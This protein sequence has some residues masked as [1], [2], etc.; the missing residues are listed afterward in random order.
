MPF[1][2]AL[3]TAAE[4][5]RAIEETC[6]RA[7]TLGEGQP[8]LVLTFFSLDH[9]PHA[10]Q[11]AA[12]LSQQF[13]PRC[14][15]GCMGESIVGNDQEIEQQPALSLWLGRWNQPVKVEPFHLTLEQTPDGYSL[16]GWP[17]GI[18][19]ADPA[20]SALL[21]LGDPFTFPTD[22]FLD[23]VN[24]NHVG[25]RVMGGM[26]SGA[27]E[28]GQSRLILG[29]RVLSE[30][31]VGVLLQGP[32]KIRSIVSQGCRP[33]GRHL[34][35]TKA[36]ENIIAGLGGKPPLAH[37]QQLWPELNKKDQQLLQHGLHVGRVIN[38]YQGEFQRG[39]FLVR[40]VL[41]LDQE[42]GAMAITDFIR[43]GQTVQFHVRDAETADEDLHALLK[44]DLAAHEQRPK[45][46]LLF[47][48]NGRGTRLFSQP[49]HDAR[50]IRQD[51]GELPLA[52]FFAAGELGP[53][54]GKNFIH[55][56]TASVVLFEE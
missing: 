25:L 56:F 32:M 53:V 12:T 2:A 50:A 28:P 14:L 29:D 48:C 55:G 17:D 36:R 5:S 43:V 22:A 16:L 10:E 11:I 19:E 46:A 3:S 54:G 26:A 47:T 20:Q 39:D 15:I 41:G 7:S 23:Q 30:G 21:L 13:Q 51:A 18:G 52:G 1:I 24:N 44:M 27:R 35:I 9:A 34:V 6:Q 8:D 49:H 38:E 33:I 31:A 4:T 40:N 37:L 45:A 42:S